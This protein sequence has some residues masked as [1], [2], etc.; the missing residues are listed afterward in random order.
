[1]HQ[2]A[3]MQCCRAWPHRLSAQ[4]KTEG[5]ACTQAQEGKVTMVFTAEELDYLL[6]EHAD[7]LTIVEASLTWCR[8]C[9]S[10]ER[11][12]EVGLQQVQGVFPACMPQILT[13]RNLHPAEV[14]RI[15][16]RGTLCEDVWKLQREHKGYVPEVASTARALPSALTQTLPCAGLFMHRYKIP[17]TPTFLF[18]RHKAVQ[19]QYT[20]DVSFHARSS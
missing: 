16:H 1:M 11:S 20:G 18:M 17:K 10:F 9:M 3:G 5:S 15:L 19:L 2:S 13:N 7:K 14:C 4:G 8:P 6:H 12:F